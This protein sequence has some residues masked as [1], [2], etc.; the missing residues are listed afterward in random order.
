MHTH[1]Y[2]YT[3]IQTYMRKM[4]IHVYNH[5]HILDFNLPTS[6]LLVSD[7]YDTNEYEIRFIFLIHLKRFIIDIVVIGLFLSLIYFYS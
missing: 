3:Y 2:P 4:H 5:F 1:A 7:H 6:D